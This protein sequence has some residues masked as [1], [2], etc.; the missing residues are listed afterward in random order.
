MRLSVQSFQRKFDPNDENIHQ[1][2]NEYSNTLIQQIDTMSSIASAFS[3]FAKMSI[4]DHRDYE[5][6]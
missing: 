4:V 5:D 6:G 2:V 3:N 1:K